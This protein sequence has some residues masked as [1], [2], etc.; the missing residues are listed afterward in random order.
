MK[1][2]ITTALEALTVRISIVPS[3]IIWPPRLSHTLLW[4]YIKKNW[5]FVEQTQKYSKF[6]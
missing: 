5:I 4:N 6:N 1:Q 3:N 2:V